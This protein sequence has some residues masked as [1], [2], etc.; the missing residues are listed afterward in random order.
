MI[1]RSIVM[2]GLNPALGLGHQSME[3]P[4]NLADDFIEPYRFVVE[5]YVVLHH[6]GE[7]NAQARKTL[8]GFVTH[9][10]KL[11]NG[12]YR[13]PTAINETIASYVR[14]LDGRASELSLPLDVQL[15]SYEDV[16]WA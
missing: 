1:A 12:G 6:A 7:F 9:E 3:N 10:I 14:I 13:L 8:L 5:R 4:F 15:P 16:P 11:K 2:A